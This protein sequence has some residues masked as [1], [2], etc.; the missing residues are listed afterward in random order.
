MAV[1]TLPRPLQQGVEVVTRSF[2]DGVIGQAQGPNSGISNRSQSASNLSV[3][4]HTD[5]ENWRLETG[6]GNWW[7]L[8]QNSEDYASEIPQGLANSR[9][10]RAYFCEP[11]IAYRDAT[12]WLG[13]QQSLFEQKPSQDNM[14]AQYELFRYRQKYRQFL[15]VVFCPMNPP[16]S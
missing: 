15:A 1:S 13:R 7:D 11:D 10:C 5:I 4:S 12:G 9:E 6:A 16:R 14:L 3:A 2:T 8:T